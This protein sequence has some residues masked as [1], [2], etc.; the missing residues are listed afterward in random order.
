MPDTRRRGQGKAAFTAFRLST[1]V[2]PD[3]DGA[4]PLQDFPTM[5]SNSQET[6]ATA[7]QTVVLE[8]GSVYESLCG[9]IN[10]KPVH[11]ARPIEAFQDNDLLSDTSADER[12]AR[13]MGVFLDMVQDSSKPVDRLDK[14]LLDFHIGVLDRKISRQLDAVMHTR[15]FR[16]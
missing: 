8:R 13:A 11:E 9:R 3:Q 7:S 14:N 6:H 10:L 12:L 1:R 15:L 4:P 2:P 16:R 5:S